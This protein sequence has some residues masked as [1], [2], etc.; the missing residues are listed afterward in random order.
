MKLN[1]FL[2]VKNSKKKN[3]AL[4]NWKKN[5]NENWYEIFVNDTFKLSLQRKYKIQNEIIL[6]LNMAQNKSQVVNYLKL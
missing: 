6:N 4:K 5:N 1:F 3:M 2:I